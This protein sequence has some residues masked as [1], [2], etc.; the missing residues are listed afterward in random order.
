MKYVTRTYAGILG[1]IRSYGRHD[2][3]FV[4][5][6]ISFYGL[7]SL[8]PLLLVTVALLDALFPTAPVLAEIVGQIEVVAPGSGALIG[9]TVSEA[10]RAR[11]QVSILAALTLLWSASG[12]FSA[13]SRA[14]NR[15]YNVRTPRHFIGHRLMALAVAVVGMVAFMA[16]FVVTIAVQLGERLPF[17]ILGL[18]IMSRA[19]FWRFVSAGGTLLMTL[20]AFTVVYWRLPNHQ[21]PR[22][23]REVLPGAVVGAVAFDI[24]KRFFTWYIPNLSKYQLVYGS[25]AAVVVLLMYFYLGSTI[26]LFGA[27]ISAS[28]PWRARGA[29]VVAKGDHQGMGQVAGGADGRA[30][31][32]AAKQAASR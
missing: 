27:E 7:L 26:L 19:P 21:P 28:Y 9:G 8:F 5:A 30:A 14:L 24:A 13:M 3:A 11:P 16:P 10:L 22:T 23:M 18:K 2:G 32:R 1:L 15:I 6:A 25:L 29:A 17:N 20:S 4:A 31:D 12:V